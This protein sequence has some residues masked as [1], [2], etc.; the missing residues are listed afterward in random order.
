MSCLSCLVSAPADLFCSD[1]MWYLPTR[2]KVGLDGPPGG[3]DWFGA[4]ADKP[5]EEPTGVGEAVLDALELA[6]DNVKVCAICACCSFSCRDISLSHVTCVI[7]GCCRW[8]GLY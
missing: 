3:G 5:V 7:L 2:I 1:L 4:D 8:G 6:E